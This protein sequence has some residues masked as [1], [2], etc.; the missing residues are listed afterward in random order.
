LADFRRV[1]EDLESKISGRAG[2]LTCAS[3]AAYLVREEGSAL[4]RWSCGNTRKIGVGD[5][6]FL[7][8][9]GV[10]PRGIVASGVVIEPPYEDLHW[11]PNASEPALYVDVE[12][13]ALLNPESDDV[14]PRE[15]LGE[16]PFSD[17]H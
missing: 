8:R 16:P 9:Q 10:E 12:F 17:M 15:L 4:Q 2:A 5:R 6:V 7:L 14:L 3:R 11:D 1:E 13:D